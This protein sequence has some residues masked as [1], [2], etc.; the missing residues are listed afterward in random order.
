MEERSVVYRVLVG[1]LSVRDQVG[2]PAV[3]GSIILGLV[4]RK[5]DGGD[6][7]GRAGTG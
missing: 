4:F 6:G 2:E 5:W 7:L 1:N 3:C